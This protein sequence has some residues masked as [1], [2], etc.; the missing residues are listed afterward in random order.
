[1]DRARGGGGGG[2]LRASFVV[3]D[4]WQNCPT[5]QEVRDQGFCGSYRL[6]HGHSQGGGG[7]WVGEICQQH[8]MPETNGRTVQLYGK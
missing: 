1:M 6:S 8:L 4:Q 2:D 7:H 5:I 3:R